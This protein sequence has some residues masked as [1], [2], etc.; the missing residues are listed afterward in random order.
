[1]GQAS[2]D[3]AAV[4]DGGVSDKRRYLREQRCPPGDQG[5]AA[6]HGVGDTGPE[7]ERAVGIGGHD[8]ESGDT[9]DVD[10]HT[11]SAQAQCQ[12]GHE[13]L[14]AGD[15]LGILAPLGECADHALDGVGSDIGERRG[16]HAGDLPVPVN[17]SA[18]AET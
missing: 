3:R 11:R 14:T 16:L 7:H 4:A 12:D 18:I 1:V 15:D 10:Q 8:I 9:T 13:A 17:A 6:E 2:P 5:I